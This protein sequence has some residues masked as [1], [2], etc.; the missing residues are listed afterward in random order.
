MPPAVDASVVEAPAEGET[1]A[2]AAPESADEQPAASDADDAADRAEGAD[3][4]AP[5]PRRVPPTRPRRAAAAGAATATATATPRAARTPRTAR[6]GAHEQPEPGRVER[7]AAGAGRR[8]RR[9]RRTGCGPRP[10]AQQ[11]PRPD[12]RRRRVRH[13]DRRGRRPDPDRR[14]P[15]CARQLRVRAHDRL[16]AGHE[17][18]LRLARPGQEVQ[19]AQGRRRR[20]RDQAAPRGRA[21][22]P[23]EVQRAGQGRRGQRP[24]GRRRRR[25]RRVRQADAALP[26]GAPAP[27]DRAR[28][29]HAAHHRPG[30]P[31]RQGSARPDRRAAQG[32]QD[33]RP[34]ADRERDRDEQPR[35]PPHGRARRRASRRGH[36]HAAH[37]QGRGH[38]LDVRPPRGRPHHG[39]RARDRARQAPRRARSRRR[40]AARLDHAS[41]PCVQH[42][43]ADLGSRAHR[44]RRR[45]GAVPAEALL[46]RRAQHRERRIAH[47]PRDRARRDRVQDGRGHLR[48]VQ[49]HRQQRAAPVASAR[50]QAHL[51]GR[52]RQR[53]EHPPRRDAA[54]APTR[55]RSRG[56]CVAP[57]RASTR[58]RRSR[59]CSAS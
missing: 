57:S 4:D 3:G 31:D 1:P 40:R 18:R 13:R 51:P 58:S 42:L 41:R 59:S 47:D 22:G 15:R 39:R 16:P 56:S 8:G 14:H 23:P 53:V 45:V 46:R 37:G 2:D 34:A 32:R 20:R 49:G 54:V 48:G 10:P 28:E 11:A 50:R 29:A 30:R 21:V 36:R 33:D 5:T 25:P 12:R 27:R 35:G 19:P 6:Q 17:R 7:P 24:V 9:R 43:G 26:A 44:W 52:R 55:S 38:R